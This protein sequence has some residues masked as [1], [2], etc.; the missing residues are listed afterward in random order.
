MSGAAA[1]QNS[2]VR[3]VGQRP[4]SPAVARL[5]PA[6]GPRPSSRPVFALLRPHA[7]PPS[8]HHELLRVATTHFAHCALNIRA[9]LSHASPPLPPTRPIDQ[10]TRLVSHHHAAYVE[11]QRAQLELPS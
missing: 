9:R 3:E 7:H 11:L 4:P 8:A 6:L 1:G 2:G 5:P 10:I